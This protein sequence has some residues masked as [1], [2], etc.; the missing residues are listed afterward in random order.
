MTRG[1][2]Y[3][4]VTFLLLAALA[5]LIGVR[6]YTLESGFEIRL[7]TTPMN[8]QPLVFGEEVEF[9]YEIAHLNLTTLP[10]DNQFE[11]Y[12]TVYVK[13]GRLPGGYWVAQSTHNIPPVVRSNEI[14]LK[15]EV[16]AREYLEN[17]PP[18]VL[19]TKEITVRYGI[20]RY[21]VPRGVFEPPSGLSSPRRAITVH[22]AVNA[23]GR[24]AITGVRINN[25]FYQ[26]PI[27]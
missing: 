24:A 14:V 21:S 5:G 11:L 2:R 18:P 20:E 23:R 27:L 10:G 6:I 15:G 12:D 3:A 13:L 17:I 4:S 25:E 26:E 9:D 19:I 1:L 16:V 22:A 7:R 8:I